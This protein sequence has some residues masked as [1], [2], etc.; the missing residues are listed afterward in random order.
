MPYTF[1][2]RC[3]IFNIMEYLCTNDLGRAIA[4]YKF[5]DM[6]NSYNAAEFSFEEAQK[7]T[8]IYKKFYFL[9]EAII[10]FN[11]CYD[12]PLQI[13]YFA[14]DFFEKITSCEEYK[15]VLK[16]KCKKYKRNGNTFQETVFFE[17]IERLKQIDHNAKDFFTEFEKY[18]NFASNRDYGIRQWANNIKHQGGFVASDILKHDK[19]TYVEC[20]QDDLLTFTTEWLYP[21][22]PSFDEIITKLE[23]QKN[24]LTDFMDWLCDSIFGNSQI[25]DFKSKPKLFSAGRCTQ[26]IKSSIIIPR[27]IQQ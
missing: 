8:D 22:T 4:V 21:H 23:K 16:D 11:S 3:N 18:I 1:K 25:I 2:D 13:I 17:D 5:Y 15:K 9:K 6:S 7:Q 14:F 27:T 10:G 24:N 12:Y 19:V 26:D 20:Q